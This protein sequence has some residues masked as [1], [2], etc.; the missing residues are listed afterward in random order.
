M[1]A[2]AFD[3]QRAGRE[4][5]AALRPLGT[6]ERAAREKRY[7]KSDL[8][9]LGVTV[10]DIR[11]TVRAA[12]GR[13]RDLDREATVAWALALWREPVHEPRMA[14]V[15]AFFTGRAAIFPGCPA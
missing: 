13:H 7:L 2:G 5:I 12:A 9:F 10:P 11:R 15:A 8:D 3:A 14:A 6:A 1:Q 4:L